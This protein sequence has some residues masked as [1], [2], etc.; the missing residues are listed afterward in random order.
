MAKLLSID[1]FGCILLLA[2]SIL[3][4]YSLQE[5]GAD[6]VSWHSPQIIACLVVSAISLIGF[7]AWQE[8]LARH[9]NLPVKL[10]FPVSVLRK[11]VLSAA[12]L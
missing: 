9:P 11:R 12:I 5:A 3:L 7:L 10:L 4:I 2:G 1:F 6:V 8:Y